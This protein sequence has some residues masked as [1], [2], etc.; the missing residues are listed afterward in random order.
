MTATVTING[1]LL[2]RNEDAVL[3]GL[4]R[5]GAVAHLFDI[6]KP[7]PAPGDPPDNQ[8]QLTLSIAPAARVLAGSYQ[9]IVIVNGQQARQSPTVALVP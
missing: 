2:G 3:V 5:D 1:F 9:L 6:V 8:Q 7:L 4:F